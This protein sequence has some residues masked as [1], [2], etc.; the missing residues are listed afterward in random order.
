MDLGLDKSD[1]IKLALKW[2]SQY[3]TT[4]SLNKWFSNLTPFLSIAFI[5][6]LSAASFIYKKQQDPGAYRCKRCGNIYC[7]KCERKVFENV[8]LAKDNIC[9]MCSKTV[10]RAEELDPKVRVENLLS[11]QYYRT[12]RNLLFRIY[13]LLLPGS[14]YIYFGHPYYGIIIL[15]F[16]IFFLT[17]FMLSLSYDDFPTISFLSSVFKTTGLIGLCVTYITSQILAFKRSKQT[18]L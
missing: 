5:I 10:V 4:S 18:W 9:H 7:K 6:A 15:W 8:K 2:T 13:E 14:G 12:K 11:I 17:L 16:F 3:N 1:L